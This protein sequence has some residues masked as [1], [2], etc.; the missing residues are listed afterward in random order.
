MML[1]AKSAGT[2]TDRITLVI[3]VVGLVLAAASVA[4]QFA[5][6]TLTGSRV[7]AKILRGA[8][9]RGGLVTIA[10]AKWTA[11]Y[12]AVMASQ[13]FS[14]DVVAVAVRNVGRSPATVQRVTVCLEAGAS[15]SLI[16]TVPSLPFRLEAE[17]SAS[18]WV[19]ATE[20]RA[21]IAASKLTRSKVHIEVALGIGKTIKTKQ[22]AW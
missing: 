1:L 15:L 7:K 4:W 12:A 16:Q 10:P 8:I 3:A 21:L 20:V 14:Q 19:D 17:S 9:G 2:G 13:G 18:W 11:S 22:I 5:T 6:F